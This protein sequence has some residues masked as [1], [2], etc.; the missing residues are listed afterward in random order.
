MVD[1]DCESFKFVS[2]RFFGVRSSLSF[3]DRR[4][5]FQIGVKFFVRHS[6]SASSEG[7]FLEEQQERIQEEVRRTDDVFNDVIEMF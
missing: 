4:Y 1:D 5:S 2:R 6:F 7:A 3:G